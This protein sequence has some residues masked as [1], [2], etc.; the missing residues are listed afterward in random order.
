MPGAAGRSIGLPS[1]IKEKLVRQKRECK[2]PNGSLLMN[3]WT[4]PSDKPSLPAT[5]YRLFKTFAVAKHP[6]FD[7]GTFIGRLYVITDPGN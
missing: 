2:V 4:K 5:R 6:Q 3:D 7:V 1:R